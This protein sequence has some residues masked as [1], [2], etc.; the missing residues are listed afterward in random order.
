MTFE[1][2]KA[3]SRQALIGSDLKVLKRIFLKGILKINL[4]K[5]INRRGRKVLVRFGPSG[6]IKN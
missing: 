1:L 3:F 4:F 6:T 5:N 2:K